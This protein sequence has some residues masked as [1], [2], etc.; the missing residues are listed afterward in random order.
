MSS[1]ARRPSLRLFLTAF[2]LPFSAEERIEKVVGS[3]PS[4]QHLNLSSAAPSTPAPKA[5]S[6]AAAASNDASSK[7]LRSDD[8]AAATDKKRRRIGSGGDGAEDDEF[9]PCATPKVGE[10]RCRRG[11]S[12]VTLWPGEIQRYRRHRY[13]VGRDTAGRSPALP[14]LPSLIL[15][16]AACRMASHPS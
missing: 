11:A 16:L 3:D 6:A 7:R 14:R 1:C 12:T 13:C 4:R 5:T 15:L 9:G 2:P 8:T 10:A